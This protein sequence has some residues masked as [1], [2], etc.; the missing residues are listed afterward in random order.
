MAQVESRPRATSEV[1]DRKAVLERIKEFEAAGADQ[2][3]F[4]GAVREGTE[5]LERV[6]T[7]LGL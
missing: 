3:L 2:I 4:A 6:A 5:Q 1:Q 7:L